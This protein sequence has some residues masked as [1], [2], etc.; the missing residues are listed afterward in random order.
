MHGYC[1]TTRAP[2]SS[3][4]CAWEGDA[5]ITLV[6]GRSLPRP[7]P[8]TFSVPA[9]SQRASVQQG[10]RDLSLAEV[11][12]HIDGSAFLPVHCARGSAFRGHLCVQLPTIL[13]L[14]SLLL[15]MWRSV[16]VSLGI[17]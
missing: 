6:K 16:C 8:H 5:D 12:K 2:S 7:A 11:L 15:R 14:H 9:W 13:N 3:A 10:N 1:N 4:V 17:A